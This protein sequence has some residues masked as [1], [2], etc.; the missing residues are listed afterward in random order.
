MA[1]LSWANGL[2]TDWRR[3]AFICIFATISSD[4]RVGG[5][6]LADNPAV[7]CGGSCYFQQR[8]A[9]QVLRDL[10]AIGGRTAHVVAR[11]VVARQP[12]DRLLP[13]FRLIEALARQGRL[14]RAGAL[15]DAG[16]A[17]KGDARAQDACA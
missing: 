1:A 9:Q 10:H 6:A 17:A 3:G 13:G 8:L 11:L 7:A 14:G 15:W 16:H 2:P 5:V 4:P 12:C